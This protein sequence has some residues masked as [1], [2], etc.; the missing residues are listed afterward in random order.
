MCKKRT[1]HSSVEPL[2]VQSYSNHLE[3]HNRWFS[4]STVWNSLSILPTILL[5][6]GIWE[7]LSWVV[8]FGSPGIHEGNWGWRICFQNGSSFTC[9][10]PWCFLVSLF[11]T[12][13]HITRVFSH[14]LNFSQ[15]DSLGVFQFLLGCWLP[16]DQDRSCR[17]SKN[18]SPG[19]VYHHFYLIYWSKRPI[20]LLQG[21]NK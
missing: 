12:W 13:C 6:L 4:N 18:P 1:S 14:G 15:Q 7:G 8:C 16:R 3:L 11:S 10:T 17:S 2:I 5:A 9:W 19:L 20:L 21:L